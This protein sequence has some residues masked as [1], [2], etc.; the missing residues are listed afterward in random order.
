MRSYARLAAGGLLLAL[1]LI[2][3][4][5]VLVSKSLTDPVKR[6]Q[7]MV[8]TVAAGNL[9]AEPMEVRGRDEIADLGRSFNQMLADL[10]LHV[11]RLA[12]EQAARKAVEGELEAA[13]KIQSALLPQTFPPYPDR[14]DLDLH[15]TLIPAKAVAG[16]FYDFF[17][18]DENTL[19]LVVADVSGKGVPAALFMAV[20]RTLLRNIA[21]VTRDPGEILKRCG[22]MLSQDNAGTMFVTCFLGVYDFRTG[23]LSHANA[24]HPPPYRIDAQGNVTVFGEPTGTLMGIFPDAD[25]GTLQTQLD[26]G[27]R[28]VLFT[29]GVTEAEA[30]DGSMLEEEGLERL[31]QEK[32]DGDATALCDHICQRVTEFQ[33][34]EQ[35]DDVTVLV[36]GRP[37]S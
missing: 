22:Q 8:R 24:G 27:D 6:L 34:G 37:V 26:P 17:L 35:S 32:L 12:E 10:R 33:Q 30:P 18:L 28:L 11:K 31:L 29:D 4:A 36:F 5:V 15:A 3:I 14:D 19:G 13:R 21:T 25:Y 2:V 7:G 1:V 9:D 20:A 16:D 23:V